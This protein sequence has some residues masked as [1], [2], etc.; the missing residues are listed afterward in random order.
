MKRMFKKGEF[1][2]MIVN[3][4]GHISMQKALRIMLDAPIGSKVV[5]VDAEISGKSGGKGSKFTFEV[6]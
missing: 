5:L 6:L 4:D 2:P 1:K 3:K